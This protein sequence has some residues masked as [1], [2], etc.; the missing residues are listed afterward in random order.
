MSTI[1]SGAIPHVRLIFKL[2]KLSSWK[3]SFLSIVGRV[4]LV[5]SVVYGMLNHTISIYSWPINL[6]KT[7][8]GW[9]RNFI[10]SGDVNKR[11]LVTVSWINV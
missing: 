3:P 1:Y 8:E 10:W 11:K 7:A 2:D 6:I 9:I 5:K 4:Q